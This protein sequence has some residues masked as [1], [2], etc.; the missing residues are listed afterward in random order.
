MNRQYDLRDAAGPDTP[1][2]R[3]DTVIIGGGQAGLSVGHH[4]AK[5]GRSF[6]ILDE[7][8]RTGDRWRE[9]YDSLRLYSPAKYNGLPGMPFPAS[10]YTFPSGR[11]MAD[12]LETYAAQL[13]LPILAGVQVDGVWPAKGAQHAYTVTA[14]QRRIAAAQVVV[15]TGGQQLPSAPS[16]ADQLDP[17]IRQLHSADYRKPSQLLPGDVLVVGASHSGADIAL[18]VAAAGHKTWLSGPVH[19]QIPFDIEGRPARQIMRLLWFAANHVLTMKTPLGRKMQ[20]EVRAHGGPLLRVKLPHLHAAGVEYVS[21]RTV[22]TR[23][24]LPVLDDGRALDVANVVW[25]TGFRP[26]FSWIHLPVIGSDGWPQQERGI[27][28]AAPGLYFVGLL[29]QYA[30]SSMLVGGVGRDAEHVAKHIARQPKA[31]RASRPSAE[32]AAASTR[33]S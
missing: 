7:H 8:G 23:A 4:L 31:K 16:F 17:G 20:P 15:A 2:E 32:P 25:C 22:G 14:G 9:H 11:Q 24:G 5:L 1:A 6:V 28:A 27:T 18:E 19:G 10:P 30:F 29:F 21:A 12:Y 33:I 26:D 13:Q 3:F